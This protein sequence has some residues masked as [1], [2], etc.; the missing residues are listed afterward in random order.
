MHNESYPTIGVVAALPAEAGVLTRVTDMI[1][2]RS[3]AKGKII[4][5][6]SGIGMQSARIQA[7][8]LA[9]ISELLVS[10]GISG[11][12]NP[13]LKAGDLILADLVMAWN[14]DLHELSQTQVMPAT[15][16]A[17]ERITNYIAEKFQENIIHFY[18]GPILCSSKPI[19]TATS[20]LSAHRLTGA[21][22]ADMESKAICEVA[23]EAGI[24]FF[25]LRA[26]CDPASQTVA[27]FFPAMLDKQGNPRIGHILAHLVRRP[28]LLRDMIRM[29]SQFRRALFALEAAWLLVGEHFL[30]SANARYVISPVRAGK[31]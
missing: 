14:N 22:A 31:R 30:S 7:E 4:I 16:R 3:S 29:A 17:D 11:G 13:L 18:R 20:K 6:K 12:L 21:L 8:Y 28:W 9:D 5:R 23:A 24:P 26:V 1:M 19:S 27:D 2:E 15:F 10:F 25:C